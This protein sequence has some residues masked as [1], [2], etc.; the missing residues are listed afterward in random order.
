MSKNQDHLKYQTHLDKTIDTNMSHL[1]G[2][3][4]AHYSELIDSFGEPLPRQDGKTRAEW[5][6]E[7]GDG[8]VA[9]IYD[10]KTEEPLGSLQRWN[11]GG[12]KPEAVELV[13]LAIETNHREYR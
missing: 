13:E 10:W 4:T 9:A 12:F 3:I 8:T 6:V 2:F 7:F 11:I 5:H 1:Q